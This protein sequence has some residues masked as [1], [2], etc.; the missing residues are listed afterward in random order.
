M[1][2]SSKIWIALGLLILIPIMYFTMEQLIY[3]SEWNEK[4]LVDCKVLDKKDDIHHNGRSPGRSN[5][6]VFVVQSP[7]HIVSINVSDELWYTTNV[8]DV[9]QAHLRKYEIYNKTRTYDDNYWFLTWLCALIGC[10]AWIALPIV[11]FV[12]LI[13]WINRKLQVFNKPK[14]T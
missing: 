6:K 8:G 9:I 14:T 3:D 12:Y 4:S 5:Y 2:N 10:I 1:K 13:K 11:A 7:N